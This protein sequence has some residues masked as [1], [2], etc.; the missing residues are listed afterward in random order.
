MHADESGHPFLPALIVPETLQ[1]LLASGSQVG[2][3]DVREEGE[4]NSSHIPTAVCAP[5]RLLETRIAQLFPFKGEQLVVC[6][7]TGARGIRAAQTLQEMG[8]TRVAL[9]W[10][11]V[12]RWFSEDRPTEWGINVPSKE[13]G[14]R[15]EVTEK[16][17]TWTAVEL[18]HHMSRD[19]S[20]RVFDT[21]TP[22]E[23]Q[24]FSIPGAECIPNVEIALRADDIARESRGTTIVINC[25]GRT[26]SIIG[27]STLRRMGIDNVVSLKNGTSG[28]ALAGFQVEHG[29]RRVGLRPPSA[30][31]IAIA[32]RHAR[33][34]AREDGVK[35]ISI[36]ALG[37]L[38]V[39]AKHS[40][41]YRIDVR[42]GDEYVRGHIPGFA[43]FPGG[44]AIQRSDDA[45]PIR[46][47]PV[48]FCCDRIARA[49]I[50]AS[51]FRRM[52]FPKV[53]V[54]NGGVEAWLK[55]GGMLED[56]NPFERAA[57]FEK[58]LSRQQRVSPR[59]LASELSAAASP[60]VI[61]VGTS[62]DFADGHVPGSKWISRSW[63]DIKIGEICPDRKARIILTDTDG[64]TARMGAHD[65]AR[66]GYEDCATLD[67]GIRAWT[68]VELE[69]ERGLTNVT[70][71]PEDVLPTI[72]YR[73]FENMMNYL[74]WEEALGHKHI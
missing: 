46:G 1:F 35:V 27:A 61:F 11:G 12:N 62:R 38:Q 69:L 21:R 36:S 7:D 28:W 73:S 74:R 29:N 37:R 2:L 8:Y 57:G 44:Q 18:A 3:L 23:F 20:I 59:Q 45:V 66:L 53:M 63:L 64:L 5:R 32:G 4:F 72:P 51:W 34:V 9:L 40:T 71:P 17:P 60:K 16:V 25:G 56:G 52:G 70:V 13:F 30:R 54:L 41:I 55:S 31:S 15:V 14:E 26:R 65:L 48:I 10:G 67:G 43:W 6:D 50:T 24:R 19:P 42:T 49:A 58:M 68:A 33:R 22:E 39:H 47:S